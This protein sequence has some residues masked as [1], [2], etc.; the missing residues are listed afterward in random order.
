MVE[1]GGEGEWRTAG[2]P[3]QGAG[4]R[5]ADV[6]RRGRSWEG[7]EWE[8]EAEPA[9]GGERAGGWVW[10]LWGS[11]RCLVTGL[12]EAP[13]Q[14]VKLSQAAPMWVGAEQQGGDRKR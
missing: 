4:A 7:E 2:T 3:W 12:A 11:T 10:K 9:I 1:V 6:V 5:A 14:R 8:G 13:R